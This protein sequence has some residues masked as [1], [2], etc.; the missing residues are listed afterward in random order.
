VGI[1]LPGWLEY[2]GGLVGEKFPEGDET[3]CRRQR[4]RWQDFANQLEGHNDGIE[5]AAKAALD[6][7]SSG[8]THDALGPQLSSLTS[9]DQSIEKIAEQ[10]RQLAHAV[11]EAATEIEYA[12]Q[13]F[14]LNLGILAASI[15]AMIASAWI[16]WGA[17]A[18]I[19]AAVAAM[20]AVLSHVI[21]AAI[22]KLVSAAALRIIERLA[23][24]ALE[25]AAINAF[26]SGGMDAAVQGGQIAAGNRHG[27]DWG[28]FGDDVG[29]GAIQGGVAAPFLRGVHERTPGF[30]TSERLSEFG[31]SFTGNTIGGLAAQAPSG[32]F[33]LGNAAKGGAAFGAMD[34]ARS[35]PK[36]IKSDWAGGGAPGDRSASHAP[37][38]KPDAL[39]PKGPE[40]A[41][42]AP[43]APAHGTEGTHD[44]SG[45]V[46]VPL[47]LGTGDHGGGGSEVT[48]SGGD[49]ASAAPPAPPEPATPRTSVS[50]TSAPSSAQ[51]TGTPA[52]RSADSVAPQASAGRDVADT[53][54]PSPGMTDTSRRPPGHHDLAEPVA[55]PTGADRA[56]TAPAAKAPDLAEPVAPRGVDLAAPPRPPEL[57]DPALP[58]KTSDRVDAAS[59]PRGSD[60]VDAVQ[61]KSEGARPADSS[62]PQMGA[63]KTAGAAPTA[64]SSAGPAKPETRAT[65]DAGAS[66]A[67]SKKSGDASLD[68]AQRH[69]H[70]S[71][72]AAAMSPFVV[73]PGVPGIDRAPHSGSA[74][75][76]P[77]P[78]APKTRD[79]VGPDRPNSEP[80]GPE[81]KGPERF[82]PARATPPVDV[83]EQHPHPNRDPDG[84]PPDTH[85]ERV[86]PSELPPYR[87]RQ[88]ELALSPEK[89]ERDLLD[90]GCPPD[91]AATA[92]NSPYEGMTRQEL[93]DRYCNPDGSVRWPPHDGF[94]DGRY[95]VTDRIPEGE[96]LDRIGEILPQ[97]GDF[98]GSAG[99][100]YP[101]RALAPGSSGPYHRLEG[102][103]KQ[104]PTDWELRY[105][106]IAE[107]F[108]QRGGGKQWV[109][110]DTSDV[111]NGA[112]R[113][114]YIDALIDGGY[115]RP[116]EVHAQAPLAGAAD[117]EHPSVRS[118]HEERVHQL[119]DEYHQHLAAHPSEAAGPHHDWDAPHHD[120]EPIFHGE[121][122]TADERQALRD[123]WHGLSDDE[124]RYPYS[125]EPMFGEHAELPVA[126]CDHYAR[127]AIGDMRR[128]L[129]GSTDRRVMAAGDEDRLRALDNIEKSLVGGPDQ[130]DRF[131]LGFE[132][133]GRSIT[134][135]G[136][137][138]TASATVVF[139][140]GT[141]TSDQKLNDHLEGPGLKNLFGL[142]ERFNK[143]GYMTITERINYVV[144]ERLGHDD[145]AVIDYQNYHA[146]QSLANP[147]TGAPNPRFAEEGAPSLRNHLDRLQHTSQVQSGK[148]WVAGHSYGTVLAGE[149]A[150]GGH[151]LNADGI[152]NLGSPGMRVHDVSGLQL[153]G[154]HLIPGDAPVHTMTRVDDPIHFVDGA[155]MMGL[156]HLNV[157]HGLM[158]HHSE[159]GGHVWDVDTNAGAQRDP[160]NAYFEPEGVALENIAKIVA[161][162]SPPPV[163]PR[164]WNTR[165]P[166]PFTTG[167]F[168]PTPTNAESDTYQSELAPADPANSNEP[169]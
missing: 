34:G 89:L 160:H 47:N 135:V 81:R 154:H 3:A 103:G 84:D 109:V 139:V 115:V 13:M 91:I 96:P 163:V 70:G 143:V 39:S 56:E 141:F 112:P 35:T 129:V 6:G 105:G 140:P 60:R 136:N 4:D 64:D 45:A 19:A 161:G 102:T 98:M 119:V 9:G 53:T 5:A 21:R 144:A 125:R 134:A 106:K 168:R 82:V 166:L 128:E 11:D 48:H 80:Q 86:D 111:V 33:D 75:T 92:R 65:G 15:A 90:G 73:A 2:V 46:D 165:N 68:P 116:V 133:D 27:F 63:E 69:E 127:Q 58:P 57:A 150:K 62:H 40:L 110:V 153:K 8:H 117:H 14:I 97:R 167:Y 25:G 149:G 20:E 26:I 104:L 158:P 17:P 126:E 23:I 29:A 78:R 121:D 50:D 55:P 159:F 151:G 38:L 43:A 145:V 83:G 93:L 18:E 28:S 95:D 146:P 147:V 16:N 94:A 7:F 87:Q 113:K 71:L 30:H 155:R 41:E 22:G 66:H 131:L 32:Q 100:S 1:E 130:P 88:M 162:E 137:P 148:L 52:A 51:A 124:R 67:L 12:K 42:P 61:P 157:G 74:A 85:P 107:A 54:H 138:D 156:G 122:F 77:E 114:V 49:G 120:H 44:G 99:D 169:R 10:L 142:R 36:V 123:V 108:D 132:P 72:D 164:Q 79:G 152:I 37:D 101:G 59:Q 76:A 118:D 24:K 31:R